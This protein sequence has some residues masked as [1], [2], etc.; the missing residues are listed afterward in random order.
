MLA[1]GP[2]RGFT[3]VR[4]LEKV[5]EQRTRRSRENK[6][7]LSPGEARVVFQRGLAKSVRQWTLIPSYT[8][9]IPVP[10]ATFNIAKTLAGYVVVLP[11]ETTLE[12]S[13]WKGNKI[14]SRC[15][16]RPWGS[17]KISAEQSTQCE[18]S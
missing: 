13:P 3:L 12:V 15:P 16:Y 5:T 17:R 1:L 2:T 11:C 18:G 7:T 8:G 9:S 4:H 14:P 10:S 6:S